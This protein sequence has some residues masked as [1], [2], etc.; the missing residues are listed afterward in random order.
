M[1]VR[2]QFPHD[3][4]MPTPDAAARLLLFTDR[5]RAGGTSTSAKIRRYRLARLDLEGRR[6]GDRGPRYAYLK[7]SYD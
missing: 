7:R 4:G 6:G 5:P 3:R 1:A 2:R